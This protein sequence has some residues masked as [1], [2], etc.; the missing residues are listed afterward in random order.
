[1]F[2]N[3]LN[4]EL[5]FKPCS[6][7]ERRSLFYDKNSTSNDFPKII[8]YQNYHRLLSD[9]YLRSSFARRIVNK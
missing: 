5:Y 7:H 1:M 2:R 4:F 9:E 8:T 3:A 6:Q